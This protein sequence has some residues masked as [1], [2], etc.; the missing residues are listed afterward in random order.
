MSAR[1]VMAADNRGSRDADRSKCYSDI[2]LCEIF[3]DEQQFLCG[4]AGQGMGE[5]IPKIQTCRVIAFLEPPIGRPGKC[6]LVSICINCSIRPTV[7]GSRLLSNTINSSIYV[8]ADIANESAAVNAARTADALGSALADRTR[9]QR[10][11]RSSR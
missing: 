7:A 10:C 4:V 8:P 11:S 1:H 6:G 2:C 3:T 5:A 9:W